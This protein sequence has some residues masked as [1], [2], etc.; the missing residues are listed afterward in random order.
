MTDGTREQ[1]SEQ[2]PDVTAIAAR[3]TAVRERIAAAAMRAGRQVSDVTLVAVSKT[4]PVAAI[5]AARAAG[6]RAFGENRAQELRDKLSAITD[7]EWHFIGRLQTNKVKYVVP[8]AS[9]VHSLDRLELAAELDRRAAQAGV[10][11]AALVEVNTSDETSKAGVAPAA[12]RGF[13][14]GLQGFTNLHVQGLMTMAAPDDPVRARASFRQLRQLRDELRGTPAGADLRELS[15][16][17]SDD[18]EIAVEEGA[19]IVRVGSAI[20]GARRTTQ[21]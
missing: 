19:T 13:L 20:F 18:F 10:T 6:A 11:V 4:Q 21:A 7:V 12:L 16:G 8:G 2:L 14:A 5:A 15:M 17:M 3:L 1:Q 9:L